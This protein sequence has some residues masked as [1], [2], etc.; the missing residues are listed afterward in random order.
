MWDKLWNWSE[1]LEVGAD[2][3][4]YLVMALVGT[5][6]FL[7]RLGISLFAG[8]IGDFETGDASPDASTDAA[9]TLFS[10]LSVTAFVMGTGW[11]GLACRI[12][13]GLSRSVSLLLAVGFGTAMMVLASGLMAW[14]RRL[15]REVTYDPQ[16]AVGRIGSVYLPVPAAGK[17]QGQ[18]R[19]S[20]SGR[21]MVMPAVSRADRELAA[22]E[23]IRVMA[24][25]SDKT[26]VV[27]PMTG[28]SEE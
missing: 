7:L 6:L 11:M 5:A 9:F 25:R 23:D 4:V 21:M 27:E 16:T 19:V 2:A 20:V 26:L 15:N 10:L 28:S 3:S 14:T 13:W 8:D 17:G 22:F 24:V 18:V 1:M 12:D